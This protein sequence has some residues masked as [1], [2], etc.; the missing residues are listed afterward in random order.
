[1]FNNFSKNRAVYE[2]MSKNLV[3]PEGADGNTVACCMPG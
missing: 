1:M 3:E 2:K